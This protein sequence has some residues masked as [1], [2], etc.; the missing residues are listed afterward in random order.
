MPE[1][2]IR[3][4]RATRAA[5][6]WPASPPC[7]T[8]APATS[9]T[10]ACATPSTPG[11][12]PG[13]RMLVATNSL[14]ARGGHC[15]QHRLPLPAVRPRVGHART[16]WPPA[17]TGSATRCASQVKYGA[18]V[19]KVCATG[20]VL[21]L[22]R[23]GGHPAA[24]P[25]GDGRA[26]GRGPP[27]AQEDGRPRPRRRG[28][29]RWPSA[30]ASTPSSTARS[31][32]TRPLR[33]MKERGHLPGAHRDGRR[34]HRA[35]AAQLPAGDR[36]QGQGGGGRARR[37]PCAGG[38]AGREDRLRHRLRRQPPRPQ[39]ARSSPCSWTTACRRPR[40]CARPPSVAAEL[41]GIEKEVGTLEAGKDADVV[42][43]ARRPAGRHPRHREGAVRDAR[44]QGAPP[45]PGA[46]HRGTIAI[47]RRSGARSSRS[48][49]ARRLQRG[50]RGVPSPRSAQR[51]LAR[52]FSSLERARPLAPVNASPCSRSTA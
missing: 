31:S 7:A 18:D 40:P 50:R 3:A 28:R 23:R 30:P 47:V 19:I 37:R 42:A 12:V 45:G 13:P 4:D 11:V 48:S 51:S 10:W 38:P 43:V 17:P 24:H 16:A 5:R 49:G 9:S 20:G 14:G 26:R 15:D 6:C 27:P 25:G 32:T 34:V 46:K 1:T 2:A 21:S 36:G 44:R 41:L 52:D 33:M 8:S 22:A 35:P 29:P 39:R